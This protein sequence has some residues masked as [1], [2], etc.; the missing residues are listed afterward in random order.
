MPLVETFL[1]TALLV[2][3]LLC[4]GSDDTESVAR[5][6]AVL[7]PTALDPAWLAA[8]RHPQTGLLS[9]G[10]RSDE[11]EAYF[12]IL[13]HA[14]QVPV[15]QLKAAA[16]QFQIER[17]GIVKNDPNYRFYFRK[18]DAEF[19]TFVDVYRAFDAYHGQPVTLR[20]HVRRLIS[21]S[22]GENAHGLRQLH[23]AWLYVGEAQQNPVVVVVSELPKGMPTGADILID[24][25]SVTGYVFKRYGYED[26]AGQ[27]RFAPLILAHKP[28]WNPPAQRH[29]WLSSTASFGLTILLGIV[30]SG[31]WWQTT[32]RRHRSV[33]QQDEVF[34]AP[35]EEP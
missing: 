10:I 15:P 20:G 31:L 30:F 19:P 11:A 12:A 35:V 24:D 23:E 7:E 17:L 13:N 6:P 26:R 3:L 27:S 14:R 16:K 29:P 1:Q 21:F 8:A 34:I 4:G 33:L 22:A 5:D 32:Q 28:E 9:R 2:S 25:V 18:P